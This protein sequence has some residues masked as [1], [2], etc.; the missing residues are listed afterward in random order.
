MQNSKLKSEIK[1]LPLSQG[2]YLFKDNKN[3]VLYVG[4]AINL[5][6]R[7]KSYFEKIPKD[8]RINNL[9]KQTKKIDYI[10]TTSEMEALLLEA[11]LTKEYQPKFNVRLKDDKRYLYAAISKEKFPRVFLLRAPEKTDKISAWFG[12]FPSAQSIKEILRL[13]RRIFPFRSCR[14]IPKKTCLYFYLNLCPGVCENLV[15]PKEYQKTTK[16]IKLF[17]EGKI[18]FLK[19]KI[20]KEMNQKA[21]ELAFEQAEKC[22]RQILMIENMLGTFKRLPE[23]E[24][25]EKQLNWLRKILIK[26]Q[27]IDPVVIYRLEAYDIANLGR[28]IV[29]GAMAVF[30]NGEPANREY[31]QFKI[32][33]K[34]EGDSQ[35]L[36][37]ILFRRLSHNEW[38]Y[39]QVILID[40]GKAQVSTVFQVLAAKKLIKQIALL[41]LAKEK[42]SVVIPLIEED[43]IKSWKILRKSSQNIGIS[44]LQYARDEAHRFAQRYY[45]KLHQKFIFSSGQE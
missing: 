33:T 8:D 15:S 9:L 34:F 23:E 19:K 25:E 4:K 17:L 12:P 36:K 40:G 37:E 42:E 6:K 22:R 3:N 2:V 5:R 38:L 29:V 24:R 43:K 7:V 13:L 18:G 26:Y 14:K 45:K 28:N 41:G 16:K 21:K 44:L 30:I 39:P 27:K 11:K 20:E 32:K 31:R 35:A 1:K 10:C